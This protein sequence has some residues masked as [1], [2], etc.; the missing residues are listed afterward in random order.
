MVRQHLWEV[1]L[2]K[3]YRELSQI[4]SFEDRFKYLQLNGAVGSAT[5]GSHRYLNQLLYRS[6]KWK[7]VRRQ[8]IIRDN[9]CDL[10]HKDHEILS[11]PV[12]IHH[13][14]PITIED[15]QSERSNVFDPDNLITT[16]FLTHQAIHY[17][18]QSLL[19]TIDTPRT[20]NDT[21]PWK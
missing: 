4:E 10:G 21:C 7:A 15:I 6:A 9:A 11:Q 2:I 17:G 18:D 5:F 13:I 1:T 3:S 19:I 12:F 20:P 8:V 16:T 14:N